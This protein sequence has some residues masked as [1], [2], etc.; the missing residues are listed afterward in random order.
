MG[1][2]GSVGHRDCVINQLRLKGTYQRSSGVIKSDDGAFSLRIEVPIIDLA[3][4]P[5]AVG[6]LP[7]TQDTAL[8]G[9]S[10]AGER[11]RVDCFSPAFTGNAGKF[12]SAVA[13]L[14]R[15]TYLRNHLLLRQFRLL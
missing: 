11:Q 15:L 7:L 8:V 10:R 6:L 2:A 3:L 13:F 9:I 5:G 14:L 12:D 4:Q 1:G